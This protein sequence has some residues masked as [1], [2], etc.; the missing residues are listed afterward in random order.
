MADRLLRR[1]LWLYPLANAGAYVAFLPLLSVAVPLRAEAIAGPGKIA[2]LSQTLL[3]GVVVAT[4]ANI[5]AGMLSD[6]SRARFGT[7]LPWLWI[8][9]VGCWLSYALIARTTGIG[10]LVAGVIL[11]QLAL[12]TLFAPLAALFAD[13]VPDRLKGRFSALTNLA[14]P[15]GS[16]GSALISLPA[17]AGD[18]ARMLALG[19]LTALLVLP[20]LLFWPAGLADIA[21][22]AP[23]PTSTGEATPGKATPGRW[24]AFRSL[25]LAKFLVQLSGTVM[26]N[27]FLFYLRGGAHDAPAAGAGVPFG[28]ARIMLLATI[29]SAVTAIAAG[30]WSDRTGRRRPFL[31]AGIA[32]MAAGL[33]L[34][35]LRHEWIAAATGYTAFAAGLGTFLTIDVALVT[36]ILPSEHHRGRDLG[37]MNGAN[38][39]PAMIGPL[40]ALT[41]LTGSAGDY[42][43]LFAVLLAALAASAITLATSTALR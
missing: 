7:R 11:F 14:L 25:W 26:T 36:Q 4:I 22:P 28:F 18:G 29:V 3:A 34:L 15:A 33:L 17:F 27:Y 19:G 39:L 24:S 38:T 6:W 10:G 31:L 13:K 43:M 5:V 35:I 23:P 12:N 20:L 37:L 21:E 2:L 40:L 9:L 42:A 1:F 8:G 41:V 30:R 32:M 16:L